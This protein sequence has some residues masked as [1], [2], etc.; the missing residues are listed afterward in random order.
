MLATSVV[1]AAS[2][3]VGWDALPQIL[4]KIKAPEFPDRSFDVTDFGA[5]EG[6]E[7]LCTEAIKEVIA[8]CVKAGGGKVVVPAGRFLT[9]PIHL[10]SNVN[11]VVSKGT[12]LV[13]SDNPEHYLP[14][15]LVRWEGE[16]CYNLS[17]LIYANGCENIAITGE[18]TLDGQ[19]PK[20]WEWR[21]REGDPYRVA[22]TIKMGWAREGMP[23]EERV[24]GEGDMRWCPT[25]ISPINCKNVLIEGLTLI[26]G[27]FWNVQPVY[28]ENVTIRGLEIINDGPNG[29]GCNPS[30]CKY[31]LIE[32]CV[33]KTGDDCIAIKSGKNEDGRRVGRASEYIVIRNCV[34]KDGHGGVVIGSEMSGDVRNVYAEDCVMDSPNLDRALRIKTNSE[35]GGVVEN[36]YM[37]NVEVGQVGQAVLKINFFY[38]DVDVGDHTPSVRNINLENVTCE[39]SDYGIWIKGYERS[40][41]TGVTLI[42]CSFNNVEKGNVLEGV[43]DLEL[44]RVTINGERVH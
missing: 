36:V 7:V 39:K 4:A 40:P 37:R 8:A 19:G 13:F 30:S 10:Q 43:T 32:D 15:V 20:W 14:A 38:S 27:P 34:M 11:L 44:R 42:N 3:A 28:C 33:F 29:D 35:R 21:E 5:K 16:E 6:G 1:Q 31:V 25:F 22:N 9:G 41:I 17:P 18:G 26:D 2:E 12:T 24:M 23:V